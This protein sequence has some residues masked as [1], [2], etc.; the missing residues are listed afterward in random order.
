MLGLLPLAISI[1]LGVSLLFSEVFGIAAGGMVVP[2]YLALHLHRPL[3]VIATLATGLATFAVV[4]AL[5]TVMVVYGRRR[6]VLMILVGYVLGTLVR[7]VTTGNY[8]PQISGFDVIGY[9]IPGLLGIWFARQ[10]IVE[11]L[12]TAITAAVFVR[13]VLLITVGEE[14]GP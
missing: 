8:A 7:W 5:S 1:G 6:T 14:L 9:I 3:D 11:T 4:Q 13:L 12:S 2:G 10:G